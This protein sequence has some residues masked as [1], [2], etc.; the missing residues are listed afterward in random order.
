M[1]ELLTSHTKITQLIWQNLAFC[2]WRQHD[3][4]REFPAST[5][6]VPFS[7]FS[8]LHHIKVPN[9]ASNDAED[10]NAKHL[11]YFKTM[12]R[13]KTKTPHLVLY[14]CGYSLSSNLMSC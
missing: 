4:T 11:V 8:S 1:K 13:N 2:L 5:Y 7:V 6:C 14:Y 12:F 9:A 3:R 10:I